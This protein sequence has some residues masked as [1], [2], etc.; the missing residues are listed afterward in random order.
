VLCTEKRE[1]K[2]YDM[3]VYTNQFQVV[4]NIAKLIGVILGSGPE[5][6]P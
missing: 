2:K 1:M 3:R 4:S 6:N 5:Q